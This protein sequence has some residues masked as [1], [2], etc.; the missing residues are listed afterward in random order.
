MTS[1]IDMR[2][3][4]KKGVCIVGGGFSNKG[5][6]AMV[7][8][9]ADAL[10]RQMP[11]ISVYAEVPGRDFAQACAGGVLPV[12]SDRSKFLGLGLIDKI[13]VTRLHNTALALIDVGGYQFGD[14]WKAQSALRKAAIVEQYVR[15]GS[16]VFFMPQ[17]WGPFSS[18]GMADATRAIIEHAT[19]SY[20]RDRTSMQAV[21]GLMGKGHAKVCFAHDIAWNF[22]GA[23]LSVGRRMIRDSG[24]LPEGGSILVGITPN[25]QVY[26]RAEGQEQDNTYVRLMRGIITYLC[27][28]HGAR[29]VLIGHEIRPDNSKVKD[30]R[31]LCNCL[32]YSVDR[33]LPVA[34]VDKVLSAAE[35]KSVLG[36]C[37]LVLS[38]RYH[39]LIA[40]LSQSIPVATVG[41]SH[42]YDE[43]M[44]EIG[45][46]SNIIPLSGTT[47]EVTRIINSIVESLPR[48]RQ[49]LPSRIAPM[50][51]S[52]AAAMNEV[53][54]VI[55]QA[56]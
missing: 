9:I 10:R 17:A 6:E 22:Q 56:C 8:T 1:V 12:R 45:L 16:P 4:K 38:S 53:L 3:S 51:D 33:S 5:A 50:K 52:G 11:G 40:A 37:D 44:S 19:L 20:V 49:A 23:D 18:P 34:H 28:A 27:S 2:I 55:E 54:S 48:V 47:D 13:R 32:L 25:R 46:T 26:Q 7:L 31:T 15:R 42:K 43:L 29:V 30:D 21:E 35:V 14:P 39:G 24:L 36:N 41:W